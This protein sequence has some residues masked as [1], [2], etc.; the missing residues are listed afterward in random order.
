MLFSQEISLGKRF[1]VMN[2]IWIMFG[3]NEKKLQ[4]SAL[5]SLWNGIHWWSLNS[6]HNGLVNE[7]NVSMSW[8]LRVG[9]RSHHLKL[10]LN[11]LQGRHNGCNCVSNHQPL[12]CLFNR[13]FWRRSRK[14]SKL[15]VTGLCEGKSPLTGEFPALMGSNAEN[16]SIWWRNHGFADSNMPQLSGAA[17]LNSYPEM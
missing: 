13:L 2:K 17:T 5:R 15:R 9:A 16:V 4:S 1:A 6:P 8:R 3:L 14:T 10:S 12:D 7:E 11:T